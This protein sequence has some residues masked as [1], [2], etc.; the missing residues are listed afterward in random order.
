[1]KNTATSLFCYLL[2]G[3]KQRIHK[4]VYALHGHTAVSNT[5]DIKEK[6][7]L[8]VPVNIYDVLRD[9]TFNLFVT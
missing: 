6:E 5:Y 7:Y 3:A 4:M 1:M 2:R 8:Q 9:Q